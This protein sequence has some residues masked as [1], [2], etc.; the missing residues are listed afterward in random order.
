M[1]LGFEAY[2]DACQES[3]YIDNDSRD[4]A[5][6]LVGHSQG[7]AVANMVVADLMNTA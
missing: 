3:G 6:W 7:A 4:N 5:V 1:R 2:A